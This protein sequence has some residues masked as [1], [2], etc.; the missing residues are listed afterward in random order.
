MFS[1]GHHRISILFVFIFY[2]WAFDDDW[3]IPADDGLQAHVLWSDDTAAW[4]Q[5]NIAY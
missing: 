3:D 1:V 2:F 4:C 5:S